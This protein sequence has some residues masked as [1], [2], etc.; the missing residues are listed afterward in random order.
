MTGVGGRKLDAAARLPCF[1]LAWF[2]RNVI[3]CRHRTVGIGVWQYSNHCMR[4]QA[5]ANAGGTRRWLQL[6]C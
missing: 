1:L 6:L 4:K 5:G 3:F 2:E